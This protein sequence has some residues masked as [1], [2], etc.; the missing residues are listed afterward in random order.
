MTG[1][2]AVSIKFGDQEYYLGMEEIVPGDTITVKEIKVSRN[3]DGALDVVI[4][5]N[6][7]QG[8][9]M[10]IELTYSGE[11]TIVWRGK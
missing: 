8:K 5:Y 7:E 11:Y 1:K 10:P 2:T 6:N 9:V 4:T 3:E